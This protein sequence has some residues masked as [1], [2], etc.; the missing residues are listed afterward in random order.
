MG[1]T[2]PPLVL[3]RCEATPGLLVGLRVGGTKPPNLEKSYVCS[4]LH[5]TRPHCSVDYYPPPDLYKGGKP[6][7]G[8][9][10]LRRE[11]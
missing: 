11:M 9:F 1:G 2:N 3:K 8:F 10:Y 7:V 5:I 4:G 6:V